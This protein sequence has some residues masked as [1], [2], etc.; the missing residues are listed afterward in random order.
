M[1]E[2]PCSHFP[3]L[4]VTTKAGKAEKDKASAEHQARARRRDGDGATMAAVVDVVAV[5]TER[6]DLGPSL[7]DRPRPVSRR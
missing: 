2:V 5:G 6:E 3:P 4:P 1:Y 7:L